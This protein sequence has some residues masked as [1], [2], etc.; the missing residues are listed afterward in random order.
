MTI[1]KRIKELRTGMGI[2]QVDFA[3]KIGVSK[4]TLYKYENDII[5]NIPSDKIELIA[6]K[7]NTTPAYI[8]GWMSDEEIEHESEEIKYNSDDIVRDESERKLLMLCRNAT[9]ANPEDK[10]ALIETFESTI[11]MYL[12]AKGLK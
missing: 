8:M 12:K 6:E 7:T 3:K 2:N 11:D 10:E 1:G 9:K 4:Q 5:T